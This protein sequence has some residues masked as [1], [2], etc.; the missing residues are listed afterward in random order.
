MN[1]EQAMTINDLF[2]FEKRIGSK[3]NTSEELY[4]VPRDSYVRIVDEEIKLPPANYSTITLRKGVVVHF[5][6]IDGMYSYCT[7][8]FG[9]VIHL[10][11]WTLV[12]LACEEDF[13]NQLII[14]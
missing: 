8:I 1:K 10:A 9:N 11:A 7:D 4:N 12:E 13:N 6:H 3:I 14:E 5:D 2:R